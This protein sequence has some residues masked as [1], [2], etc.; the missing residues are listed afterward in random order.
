M[1]NRFNKRYRA[2]ISEIG[3]ERLL[4]FFMSAWFVS[5]CKYHGI[6]WG[7][8]GYVLLVTFATIKEYII[9]EKPSLKDG[10]WTFFGGTFSIL[11][12]LLDMFL[13]NMFK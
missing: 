1:R 3:I 13:K 5:E 7:L 6:L 2:I 10:L 11:I 4:Y 12:I 8:F 9:D